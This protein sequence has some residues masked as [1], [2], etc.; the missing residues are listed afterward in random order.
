MCDLLQHYLWHSQLM[1]EIPYFFLLVFPPIHSVS[2]TSSH[3]KHIELTLLPNSATWNSHVSLWW[4]HVCY[5]YNFAD[6]VPVKNYIMLNQSLII[7]CCCNFLLQS[8]LYLYILFCYLCYLLNDCFLL[9]SSLLYRD[10]IH[11]ILFLCNMVCRHYQ[12]MK[13][14]NILFSKLYCYKKNCHEIK[15]SKHL[16]LFWQIWIG[17]DYEDEEV[18]DLN[19]F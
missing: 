19:L 6:V 13:H 14:K 7:G 9:P 18:S 10:F 5:M 17:E 3:L 1:S 12:T 4:A 11:T 8:V 15:R 16:N 2:C